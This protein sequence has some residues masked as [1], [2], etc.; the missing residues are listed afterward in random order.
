[1]LLEGQIRFAFIEEATTLCRMQNVRPILIECQDDV[2]F[3]RLRVQRLEPELASETPSGWA[4]F[5]RDEAV[6]KGYEIIDTGVVPMPDTVHR[7]SLYLAS[8]LGS[9]AVGAPLRS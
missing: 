7:L 8:A 1:M 2:R 3:S 4:R 5:L 9:L 6:S